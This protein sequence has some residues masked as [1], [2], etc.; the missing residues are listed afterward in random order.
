MP[1]LAYPFHWSIPTGLSCQRV[2]ARQEAYVSPS[3][4]STHHSIFSSTWAS[5]RGGV[6]DL[7]SGQ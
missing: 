6:F 7:D 2:F 1:F 3:H 5:A 4:H